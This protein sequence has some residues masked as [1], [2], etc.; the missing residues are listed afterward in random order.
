MNCDAILFFFVN[1]ELDLWD[2]GSNTQLQ[3]IEPFKSYTIHCLRQYII[4]ISGKYQC[5]DL[6]LLL[7]TDVCM[8][9]MLLVL[10]CCFHVVP[11]SVVSDNNVLRVM[12]S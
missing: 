11:V 4:H 8:S 10:L 12:F 3:K 7:W 5:G 2:H 9:F 1:I 6:S